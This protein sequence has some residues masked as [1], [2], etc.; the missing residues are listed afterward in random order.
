[1]SF[2]PFWFFF[3]FCFDA[4]KLI[5]SRSQISTNTLSL[6]CSSHILSDQVEITPESR[7]NS[8]QTALLAHN[9]AD[10][11]KI[12]GSAVTNQDIRWH[13]F[14]SLTV[15]RA[16][17]QICMSVVLQLCYKQAVWYSRNKQTHTTTTTTTTTQKKTLQTKTR[18][19][20]SLYQDAFRLLHK[21]KS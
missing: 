10:L 9:A 19:K 6:S 2:F 5:R 21:P 20:S 13:Y 8:V 16:G 11:N 18:R 12:P 1:M 17:V 15:C 14:P 3:L 7:R 4:A